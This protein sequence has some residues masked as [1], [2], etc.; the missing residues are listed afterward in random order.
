MQNG[1]VIIRHAG[2]V[3]DLSV[4]PDGRYVASL[5]V[6]RY[7]VIHSL[8]DGRTFSFIV[9]P[10]VAPTCMCW[11]PD[12]RYVA[13][14]MS[15]SRIDIWDI[16][17]GKPTSRMLGHQESVS[18]LAW[19][20]YLASGSKDRTIRVWDYSSGDCIL[21]LRGHTSEVLGLDWLVSSDY[22]VSCGADMRI[23]LWNVSYGRQIATFSGHL[24]VV[25]S[26]V[27]ADDKTIISCG[28]DGSVRFWDTRTRRSIKVLKTGCRPECMSYEPNTMRIAVG[29]S[30]GKILL[31]NGEKKTSIDA[32]RGRVMALSWLTKGETLISGGED[33]TVKLWKL[34]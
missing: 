12:S 16:M 10:N 7:L 20:K 4:S 9:D 21:M 6:D 29:C 3:V 22:L 1:N 13:I 18:C 11:S 27:F 32:H 31:L 2:P 26:A 19:G 14:G 34:D 23:I 28:G 5:G 17:S 15:D 33:G 8:M 25:V 30:D 24:G